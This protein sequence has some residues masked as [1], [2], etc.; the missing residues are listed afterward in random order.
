MSSEEPSRCAK[1]KS[2]SRT[3]PSASIIT[4]SGFKSLHHNN[5]QGVSNSL[6][7]ATDTLPIRDHEILVEKREG[8]GDLGCVEASHCLCQLAFVSQQVEQLAAV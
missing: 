5:E 3:C 7:K 4:F 8:E 1:P 2:T 6:T